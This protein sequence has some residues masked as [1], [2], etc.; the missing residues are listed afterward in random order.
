[1][2]RFKK[3]TTGICLAL[4]MGFGVSGCD[5]FLDV[6]ED[7]NNPETVRITLML[8]GMLV[9]FGF[10]LLGPEDMR[11]GNL[12]NPTGLG[13]EWMR[14]WS[15]NN[16]RHTYAQFQW[17]QVA[18]QDSDEFWDDGY[19]DVMQECKNIMAVAEPDEE[20]A[21]HGIA[22]FM[23]AWTATILSDAFGP[24][25]LSEAFDPANPNPKYDTQQ[26]VYNS[27]FQMIDEAISEMQ[28]PSASP[29]NADVL[30]GGDMDMWVKLANTVKGRLHMRLVYAPGENSN[31][32]AQSAL[33]ALGAGIA[34][35]AEAPTIEFAGGTGNRQPW[36]KFDDQGY[37]E[38]SR[39]DWYFIEMLKA[40]NDP[41]LPIV[42]EP[43]D[44]ECPVGVGYRTEDCTVATSIIYRGNVNGGPGEPDSAISRIGKFF[45]AD[46]MPHVWIT[47][48]DI[49]FLEAEAQLIIAGAAAADPFYRGAIRANMEHVGVAAADIDTYIAAQPPLSSVANPLEELITEKYVAN[50]LQ[51]EVW[52][53]FRRTGYPDVP[54]VDPAE[55]YLDAIPQRLRTPADEMQF[56]VDAVAASGIPTS[57]DGML[58]KVWWASGG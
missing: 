41:R 47:W 40:N 21:Y 54:L 5:S 10:D 32:R 44:L 53:D 48:H 30:F 8:P 12:L 29:G 58:T 4:L 49:K 42:A 56:N 1:M 19:A 2:N 34:S 55:R 22:K 51:A 20:W 6:N 13:T 11:Y 52:H 27:A 16:D 43:A 18:N 7:P 46:S 28:M 31:E 39:S 50:F 36:Y 23:F 45:A 35:A 57:N 3:T 14:Q 26:E 9:K 17:Y 38:R 37:G 33:T 25:P 15:D 24:I